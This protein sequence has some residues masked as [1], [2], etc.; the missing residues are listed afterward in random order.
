MDAETLKALKGS[1]EKH[2][3][4]LDGSERDEGTKNC[5]LCQLFHNDRCEGCPI[6]EKTGF[7]GCEGTPYED[8]DEHQD[9]AHSGDNTVQCEECERLV[10]LEIEF[11]KSLIPISI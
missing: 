6:F 11:L 4:I 3:N 7:Q 10:K 8:W 9:E 2:E 1:I 5:P